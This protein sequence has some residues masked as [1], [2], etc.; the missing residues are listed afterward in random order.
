[1]PVS[2][3]VRGFEDARARFNATERGGADDDAFI[4]LFEVVAWTGSISERLRSEKGQ[5]PGVIQ[6]LYYVR[7]AVVHNGAETLMQ[8]TFPRPYGAGPYGGGAYGTGE[9]TEWAW[10]PRNAFP[11][12]KSKAGASEYEKLLDG[13]AVRTTLAEVSEELA[14]V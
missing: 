1:V 11:P 14:S 2:I 3:L 8:S 5:V 6:G 7:N 12:P 10:K 9:L 13:K 4:A